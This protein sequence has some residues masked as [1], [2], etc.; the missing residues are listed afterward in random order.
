M[1]YFGTTTN[2]FKHVSNDPNPPGNNATDQFRTV[3]INMLKENCSNW[4]EIYKQL[5]NMT[6]DRI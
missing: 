2:D 4:I 1:A 3:Y 5:N 6:Q